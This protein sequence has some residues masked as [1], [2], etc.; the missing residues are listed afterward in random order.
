MTEA[1]QILH[2]DDEFVAVSKPGGLLVVEGFHRDLNRE[3]VQGGYFGFG[4][5]E[6]LRAFDGLRVLRYEDRRADADWGRRAPGGRS[7]SGTSTS[8]KPLL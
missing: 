4:T 1:L 8:T 3:S 7:C 2:L 5:N 6:L